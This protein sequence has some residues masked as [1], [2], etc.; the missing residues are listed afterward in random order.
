MDTWD[1]IVRL[2]LI[3]VPHHLARMEVFAVPA[4]VNIIANAQKDIMERIVN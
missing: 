1:I 2:K 3:S 4:K